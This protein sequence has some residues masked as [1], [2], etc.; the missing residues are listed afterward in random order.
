MLKIVRK[1]NGGAMLAALI[2]MPVLAAGSLAAYQMANKSAMVTMMAAMEEDAIFASDSVAN[3][4]VGQ[5]LQTGATGDNYRREIVQ[6]ADGAWLFNHSA[7]APATLNR[8][9]N[10][11]FRYDNLS[12][13]YT[14]KKLPQTAL[15]GGA[16]A[17]T[18]A[19]EITSRT[20]NNATPTW[21][22]TPY[23]E[24][25]TQQEFNMGLVKASGCASNYDFFAENEY[26]KSVMMSMSFGNN[27]AY[28]AG[29]KWGYYGMM[30]FAMGGTQCI[31]TNGEAVMKSFW[32]PFTD[33]CGWPRVNCNVA[34]PI[35]FENALYG[36][37]DSNR[38]GQTDDHD[39]I[40]R[41]NMNG[42][43]GNSYASSYP[44]PFTSM[45]KTVIDKISKNAR[46]FTIH[47]DALTAMNG[48]GEVGRSGNWYFRDSNHDGKA[49]SDTPYFY[50]EGDLTTTVLLNMTM[51]RNKNSYMYVNGNIN[52]FQMNTA[53]SMNAGQLYVM[54]S[55]NVLT[56]NLMSM[57]MMDAGLVVL[58]G[59]SIMN[60][61]MM[62]GSGIGSGTMM[63]NNDI[64]LNTGMSMSF[65]N[66]QR[67][68]AKNNIIESG[69]MSMSMG[70]TGTGSCGCTGFADETTEMQIGRRFT[71]S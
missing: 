59:A 19:V 62:N 26:Q 36:R 33:I 31:D 9:A 60:S 17:N 65:A 27:A 54:A 38:N 25:V 24:H 13:L 44:Y 15:V 61:S 12:T 14:V 71:K 21:G 42:N 57:S 20:Y 47:A 51:F 7:N 23:V 53:L 67:L 49:D 35:T 1:D 10:A 50:H 45:E 2:L 18:I 16:E 11:D 22:T 4:L 30:S 58:A 52:N 39:G 56:L 28:Y 43:N 69:M 64:M 6:S 55:G 8:D 63:A 40:K 70:A 68:L 5:I 46:P 34:P 32:P 3:I 37:S 66:R 41:I 29:T 48:D